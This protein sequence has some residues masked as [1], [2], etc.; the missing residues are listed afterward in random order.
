[1]ASVVRLESQDLAQIAQA[2]QELTGA[3]NVRI[4][5]LIDPSLVAGFT[6]RYGEGGSKVIDMSIKKQLEE[7]ASNL[8]LPTVSLPMQ[9][10]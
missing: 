9:P 1:M 7:I 2:V 6:I 3:K 10:I 8:E 4:K 5:T